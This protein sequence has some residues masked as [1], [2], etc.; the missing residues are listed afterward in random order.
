M[1]EESTFGPYRLFKDFESGLFQS[2]NC[3][4]HHQSARL[5]LQDHFAMLTVRAELFHGGNILT[6]GIADECGARHFLEF[7]IR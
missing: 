4:L 1:T 6:D 5:A 3:S 2:A 7:F